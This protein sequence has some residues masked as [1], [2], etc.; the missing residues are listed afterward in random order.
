MVDVS[1]INIILTI[2]Q[3]S[4]YGDDIDDN[5]EDNRG[6]DGGIGGY[7]NVSGFKTEDE[8][9]AFMRICGRS[10]DWKYGLSFVTILFVGGIY[11]VHE[12]TRRIAG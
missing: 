11:P 12:C 8:V 7:S 5:D 4:I 10:S 6:S 3:R 2:F 9:I 1:N